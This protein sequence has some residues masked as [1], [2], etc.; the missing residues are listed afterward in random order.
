MEWCTWK[1]RK[2]NPEAK[3][4]K[5]DEGMRMHQKNQQI[6]WCLEY[7]YH[8]VEMLI[9]VLGVHEKIVRDFRQTD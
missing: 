9:P 4:S 8:G 7:D 2:L 1:G 5:V 6:Q 3:Q